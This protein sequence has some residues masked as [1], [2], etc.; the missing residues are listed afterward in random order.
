MLVKAGS[1]AL[2][3]GE[4]DSL[5]VPNAYTDLT[6]VLPYNDTEAVE[7]YFDKHG[8]ETACVIVEPIAGNMNCVLPDVGF[9]EALREQCTLNE[10]VLIFDE[11]M[12]GFRVALGGAQSIFG[13]V[14]DITTLGK[15]I[16]GGLPIGAF[17]GKA[18]IMQKI[19]PEG[20]VYQAGTL[21]GSPLAVAAGLA[22]LEIVS[23]ENFYETLSKKTKLLMEGLEERAS[24][25]DIAFTTNHAG[26]MFG[27][28]FNKNN[29]VKTFKEVMESNNESFQVYFHEMLNN[30]VYL[31][32]SMYEAGFI[33]MAHTE[34]EIEKT[35]DAASLAFE[36]IKTNVG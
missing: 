11:V 18:E 1:G 12:T 21:A 26:G 29:K 9:L 6:H 15:V 4:P 25:A 27:C 35:L 8:K 17:G 24:A 19:A 34:E 16:G 30:G 28:F 14:P 10:S 3:I 33:S 7:Q 2:T 31:A 36:V 23:T 22:M 5:G 13:V 32:P 20:A